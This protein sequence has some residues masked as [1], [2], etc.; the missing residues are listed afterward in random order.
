LTT[1]HPKKL[2]CS[3]SVRKNIFR[4]QM[5]VWKTKSACGCNAEDSTLTA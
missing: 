2:G 3:S 5:H 1:S 4:R